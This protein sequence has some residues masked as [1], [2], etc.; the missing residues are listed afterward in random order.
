[1]IAEDRAGRPCDFH[2]V[3]ETVTTSADCPFCVGNEH[4]TPESLVEVRDAAGN[5]QVRVV[6]NKYPAVSLDQAS[7]APSPGPLA[8]TTHAPFG[9]HEVFIESPRHVQGITD[10]SQEEL[11]TVLLVQRD[12]LRMWSSDK[13]VKY[14]ALFRNIGHPAGA[15]L[16]HIHSQLVALPEVPAVVATEVTACQLSYRQYQRCA[17]CQLLADELAEESRIVM[18]DGPFV[19]MCAYAGR[20]PYETWILPAEHQSGFENLADELFPELAAL[21]QQLA[22]GLKQVLSPLSY[23]LLL[24]TSPFGLDPAQFH[25][26]LELVPRSTQLAGF[27]W[28]T[29]MYI[30]PLSPERAAERL[31]QEIC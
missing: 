10:L 19:A 17:F 2:E 12:R 31:R 27:E 8:S 26:H 23:N 29:G 9:A 16:G 24:H 4:W 6:P 1:M 22:R 14:V 20:Q 15:S 13:R 28:G 5:W 18:S 25:W 7:F 30:N 3:D 21:L 11:T